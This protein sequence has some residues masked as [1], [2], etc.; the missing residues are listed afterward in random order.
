MD[1]KMCIRD[2]TMSTPTSM[3][4]PMTMRIPMTTRMTTNIPMLMSI[5]TTTAIPMCTEE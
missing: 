2:R 4:V 1:L 5:L 3:P